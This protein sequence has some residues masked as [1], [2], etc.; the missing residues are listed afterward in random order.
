MTQISPHF[1]LEE[2]TATNYPAMQAIPNTEQLINLV[3]LVCAVLQ[4]LRDAFGAPIRINSGFRSVT[5]NKY[6][7]GVS[8]SYHLRGLA[9]DIRVNSTA[10]AAQLVEILKK[11]KAVDLCLLEQKNSSKWLHVQTRRLS[12]PRYSFVLN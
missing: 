1:T 3:W 4:P 10:H 7:G 12:T 6:V 11:N 2:L 5:L 8:N 9:A